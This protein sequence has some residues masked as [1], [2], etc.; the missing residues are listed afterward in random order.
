MKFILPIILISISLH[1][2]LL[3]KVAAVIEKKPITFS[4]VTR[5]KNN[6]NARNMIA[7]LI[8]QKGKT[9]DK[10][11]LNTIIQ[12]HLV[13][14]KLKELGIEVQDSVVNGRIEEIRKN[15]NV[16]K[17]FLYNYLAKQGLSRQEYFDLIKQMMEISYFN[18]KIIAPLISVKDSEVSEK[19][20][21]IKS[22]IP[23][24]MIYDVTNYS[25]GPEIQKKYSN[26]ELIKILKSFRKDKS[27]LPADLQGLE[28]TD[29]TLN[30]FELN[31]NV[32]KILR[33]TRSKRFSTPKIINNYL[34]VF[35]VRSKRID[36]K[37]TPK[38]SNDMI[39]QEVAISK[40]TEEIQK[41][42]KS[43]MDESFIKIFI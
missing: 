39:K 8:Y 34:N 20:A 27:T 41:W 36:R 13:R 21:E 32:K 12:T 16:T 5:I 42:V 18:Q 30:G 7:P 43:E 37:R 11:I 15:Q 33:S 26:A 1:A 40:S 38:I 2:S 4:E 19:E 3:D 6:F 14:K 10:E 17:E 25:F 23:K 28:G 22:K 24:V 9:S 31:P 35:Y 29:I